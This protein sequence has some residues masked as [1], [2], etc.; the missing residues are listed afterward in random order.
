MPTIAV[1][2]LLMTRTDVDP[3]LTEWVTRAPVIKSRDGIGAIHSAQLVDLRTAIYTDPLPL[4]G[5]RPAL[6]PVG[7][8]SA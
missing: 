4:Q 8:A 1:S 2:N 3:R 7:E 5:G 6:L